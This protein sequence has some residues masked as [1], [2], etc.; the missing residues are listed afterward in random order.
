MDRRKAE[1]AYSWL[2]QPGIKYVKLYMDPHTQEAVNVAVEALKELLE[3]QDGKQS[4]GAEHIEL[5]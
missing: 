5:P 1:K 2:T 4:G 3:E